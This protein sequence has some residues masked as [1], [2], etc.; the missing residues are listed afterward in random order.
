MKVAPA[1]LALL[2]SV[3]ACG[4]QEATSNSAGQLDEAAAQSDPAAAAAMENAIDNGAN[5]QEALE[6]GGNAQA[7][8]V[9][10]PT[11]TPE[12]ATGA[13]PHAPGDPVPP[14]QTEATP[15]QGAAKGSNQ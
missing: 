13:K 6:A 2:V 3:G 8:T 4:G 11:T 10:Q 7:A 15:Q 9:P 1:L 14:P 12:R 5:A